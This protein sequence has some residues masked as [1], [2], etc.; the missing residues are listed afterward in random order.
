MSQGNKLQNGKEMIHLM[1]KTHHK[2]RRKKMTINKLQNGKH[3][4]HQ[5]T[6]KHNRVKR[7]KQNLKLR[8]KQP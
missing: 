3:Q 6:K 5:M 2:I 4:I 8:V 1:K 7:R